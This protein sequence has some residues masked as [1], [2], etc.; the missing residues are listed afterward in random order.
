[1]TSE[2]INDLLYNRGCSTFEGKFTDGLHPKNSEKT[3]YILHFRA[4]SGNCL[5]ML[6]FIYY[7]SF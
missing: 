7:R 5:V 1:M 2:V 6:I 4:A 3:S